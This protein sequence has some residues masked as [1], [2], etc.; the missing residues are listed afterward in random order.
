MILKIIPATLENIDD[1][2]TIENEAFSCPWS[3][4]SF[5]EA[6]LNQ[7]IS[8][9]VASSSD[10]SILGFLCLMI[11]DSEAEVLNVAV[12]EKLRKQGI[13]SMLLSHALSYAKEHSV[14][15]VYLEVRESNTA[16]QALYSNSG[17]EKIG[18]RRNYYKKPSEDAVLMQKKLI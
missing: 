17:F 10:N 15:S 14:S 5:E 6:F 18:I 9:F 4:K 11:L 3:K 12:S 13:G 16:A 1:I 8:L 2:L 7:N